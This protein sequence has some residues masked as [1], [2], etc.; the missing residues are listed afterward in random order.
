M[1]LVHFNCNA[2]NV[3]EGV[4][5]FTLTQEYNIFFLKL[6]SYRTHLDATGMT[7]AAQHTPLVGSISSTDADGVAN[8][9]TESTYHYGNTTINGAF[10]AGHIDT[11]LVSEAHNL[12]YTISN[13]FTKLG[14][15]VVINLG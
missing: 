15:N 10:H 13:E 8:L 9:A 14:P 1:V 6:V 2:T 7:N 3:V 5:S 11:G 4:A 12:D